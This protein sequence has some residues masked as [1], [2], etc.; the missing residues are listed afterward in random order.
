MSVNELFLVN[1]SNGLLSKMPV[2]IVATATATTLSQMKAQLPIV[3][4]ICQGFFGRWNIF[5]QRK[6]RQFFHYAAFPMSKMFFTHRKSFVMKVP[7][8]WSCM[9]LFNEVWYVQKLYGESSKVKI[10]LEICLMCIVGCEVDSLC[11]L[12]I[13]TAS[14]I[15]IKMKRKNCPRSFGKRL[16][17]FA[18]V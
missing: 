7:S 4:L 5:V 14:R 18:A 2:F 13:S 3:S 6:G 8:M 9:Q 17:E 15:M 16:I 12:C 11:F 1:H 10:V